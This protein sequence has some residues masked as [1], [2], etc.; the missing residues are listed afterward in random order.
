MHDAVRYALDPHQPLDAELERVG[1]EQAA[2]IRA[3][4]AEALSRPE[5]DPAGAAEPIH[6]ARKGV[7]RLRA[8]A[9]LVRSS[10]DR[11]AYEQLNARLRDAARLLSGGRDAF[12]IAGLLKSFSGELSASAVDALRPFG[13]R[14]AARGRDGA[15]ARQTAEADTMLAE[16]EAHLAQLVPARPRRARLVRSIASAYRRSRRAMAKAGRLETDEAL[17]EWR[18][19]VKY[20]RHH[21]ELLQPTAPELLEATERLW[22]DLTDRLGDYNDLATL[23]AAV[24]REI[25]SQDEDGS[26]AVALQE[27]LERIAVRQHGLRKSALHLGRQLLAERRRAYRRRLRDLW[28]PA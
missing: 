18:K 7:K 9:R 21:V 24:R 20:V 3:S 25:D 2:L 14:L 28:S 11:A 5:E 16:T 12:V 15:T 17:H 8:L 26:Q 22:H 10:I 13:G 4:L 6:E 19:S 27:L 23:A 1:R